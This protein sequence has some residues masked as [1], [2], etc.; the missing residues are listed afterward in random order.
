MLTVIILITI[1]V[2]IVIYFRKSTKAENYQSTPEVPVI[3]L[4]VQ[5]NV[6]EPNPTFVTEEAARSVEEKPKKRKYN[7]KKSPKKM[8]AKKA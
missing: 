1:I 5:E 3:E 6:S 2:G 4:P 8:D 7:K